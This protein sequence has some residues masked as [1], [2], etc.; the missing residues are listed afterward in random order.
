MFNEEAFQQALSQPR[1][2]ATGQRRDGAEVP[3]RV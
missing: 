1:L 2:Q 3:R